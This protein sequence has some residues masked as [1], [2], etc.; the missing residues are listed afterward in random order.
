V[1]IGHHS[2]EKK[3]RSPKEDSKR[4]LAEAGTGGDGFVP[5]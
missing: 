4:D 5:A 3:F 1:V 2:Q